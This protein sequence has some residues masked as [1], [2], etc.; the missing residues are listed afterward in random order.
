MDKKNYQD[1]ELALQWELIGYR[2]I[3]HIDSGYVTGF[4]IEFIRVYS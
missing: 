4:T 3:P 2:E 1:N